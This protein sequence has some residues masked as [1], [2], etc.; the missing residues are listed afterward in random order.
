MSKQ[1]GR[2]ALILS[3]LCSAAQA[4]EVGIHFVVDEHLINASNSQQA[5]IEVVESHVQE[6]NEI[7][8]DSQVDIQLKIVKLDFR[9]VSDGGELRFAPT[10]LENMQRERGVFAGVRTEDARIGADY[11]YTYVGPGLFGNRGSLCGQAIAVNDSLA[12]LQSVSLA[13][14]LS[15][16][17]CGAL[18]L[19][20]ELGHVMGLAHGNKIEECD[21]ST[22]N[23]HI[24][25]VFDFSRGWAEG[26]CD[27]EFQHG[28]FGTI[29]AG[30]ALREVVGSDFRLFVALQPVFSNPDVISSACG[31][32]RRC[33]NEQFGDAARS[34]S[35]FQDVFADHNTVDADILE[36]A[37]ANLSRCVEEAF[38]GVD[39]T[40]VINLQCSSE[41]IRHLDGIE[42]L[43]DIERFFLGNNRLVNLSP[44]LSFSNDQVIHINLEGN[45]TALCHQLEQVAERFP[46][47]VVL[48]YQCFNLGALLP[49]ISLL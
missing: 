8:A 37:D 18:T 34:L 24:Q 22:R 44:L 10:I 36:Y 14:A 13:F 35:L 46:G 26:S 1:L 27:R 41:G 4:A 43:T 20:H 17:N 49:A 2:F 38:A 9:N 33:G 32:S 11:L 25:G 19:A 30:N 21:T 23:A 48:P 29:M 28:E 5:L 47:K 7:F 3:M 39:H 45:D 31:P 42:Q 40:D 15:D 12:S 16:I 6:T